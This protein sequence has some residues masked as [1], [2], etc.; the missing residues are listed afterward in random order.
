MNKKISTKIVTLFAATI[1]FIVIAISIASYQNSYT[2]LIEIYSTKASGIAAV[3]S[4]SIQADAFNSY[5]T[6]EDTKSTSYIELL[7]KLS[8]IRKISG[9]KYLYMMKKTDE[10]KYVY[11]LD[12]SERAT[13]LGTEVPSSEAYE[14]TYQDI[15]Y[16]S[17]KID[18]SEHGELVSAM[19]PIKDSDGNVVGL[20][21]VDYD[22]HDGYLALQ[23]FKVRI[24]IWSIGFSILGI[25]ISYL[26]ARRLSKPIEMLAKTTQKISD[27]DLRVDNISIKN[28]DEIGQ[29]ATSFNMMVGSINEIITKITDTTG[30]IMHNT[31][32]LAD[33][34]HSTELAAQEVANNTSVVNES[35]QEQL[36][37][38]KDGRFKAD[39]L[40]DS[41]T[42][43]SNSISHII[44][45][46]NETSEM[47]SLNINTI[48]SLLSKWEE[49]TSVSNEVGGLVSAMHKSIE[50][51]GAITEAIGQ[52]AKQTNLLALNASIESARAGESGKGFAV[53][54]EEIR[55]LAEQSENSTK[56]IKGLVSTIQNQSEGLVFSMDKSKNV[57]S[58]QNHIIINVEDMSVK[59]SDTIKT[60]N[61]SINEVKALND[62]MVHKKNV[63]VNTIESIIISAEQTS[64]TTESTAAHTEEILAT[65]T[66][67]T[68]NAKKIKEMS[69]DLQSI[70]SKFKV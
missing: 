54:A 57:A 33:T 50:E 8:Y 18:I 62:D 58:E 52:I 38:V 10:G 19:S 40:S 36:E 41:I 59:I 70:V 56:G 2:M 68:D 20:L 63:I 6:V 66:E 12:A 44:T 43:V 47:N 4:A 13:A 29:L 9:A 30:V 34:A 31:E 17:S 35:A 16:I 3:S 67:F 64:T 7:D 60:L 39:E 48:Q 61:T 55:K 11:I 51:I 69:S 32:I 27:Y 28:K 15:P 25:L 21:G 14:Q 37:G 22:A 45:A 26:F 1:L 42:S 5:K 23:T 65:M 53:V 49:S 46:V 24:I